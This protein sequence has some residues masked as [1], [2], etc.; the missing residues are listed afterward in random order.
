M[1]TKMH[2]DD[3]AQLLQSTDVNGQRNG[4]AVAVSPETSSALSLFVLDPH[5]RDAVLAWEALER[6]ETNYRALVEIFLGRKSSHIQL[7]RQ[8]YQRKFRRQLEQD[9]I[10]TE[11]PHAFQRIIVALATSHKAHQADV[12]Q[13]LAKCDARRLFKTGEGSSLGAIEEAVVL[14]IVSK[15]SIPQLKLTFLSY[16]HIYGHDYS[17]SLKKVSATEFADALR[18]VVKCISN[19]PKYYAKMLYTNLKG[20]TVDKSALTRVMVSRAELDMSE[21]RRAFKR[22]YGVDIQDCICQ[23][24]VCG[25]Y[26][27]FLVALATK[28]S[29]ATSSSNLFHGLNQGSD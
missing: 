26:R 11:P 19:A 24:I 27:D 2:G 4:A 13:H 20:R 12:S 28:T 10:N 1:A 7:I 6:G 14:E 21:I 17:K 8:A 29:P 23:S 22:K 9:I 16:R 25:D 18:M 3:L 5:E 15:R